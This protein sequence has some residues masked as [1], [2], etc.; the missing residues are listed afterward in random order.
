MRYPAPEPIRGDVAWC[1][2]HATID[3]GSA[4]GEY[5]YIVRPGVTVRAV[6][7]GFS[8]AWFA[9]FDRHGGPTVVAANTSVRVALESLAHEMRHEA[10]RI[11]RESRELEMLAHGARAVGTL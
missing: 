3:P 7:D 9:E 6:F 5:R 11:I 1:K 2:Q 10:Q 4:P 8:W